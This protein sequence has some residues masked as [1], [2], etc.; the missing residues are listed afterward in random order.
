M[1]GIT[2]N[3]QI[4]Y[5]FFNPLGPV[6]DNARRTLLLGQS[7]DWELV[8]VAALGSLLYLA[9][10]LPHLQAA[11]GE[12]CRH[13][14]TGPSRSSTSGRSSGP[15][16]PVPKFYDQMKRFG[17][18]IGSRGRH[19]YRWVLK[20]VNLEVRPGGS[21]A[22]I[23][24]NGSGKTTLLK[25]ISQVTY[26]SAGRCDVRG[27]I[28]ALLS[29]TSGIQ[30]ELSGRENVFLYGA[31]LGHGP[32]DHPQAVR[33]DRRVRRSERRHRPAGQ[34]LLDGHADAARVLHRRLPRARRP[35]GRRGALG[36]ATPT[37]SR[38]AST[39]SG[40]WS[41]RA[42]PSSTSPTTWPR[43]RR[44]ASGPCGWPTP[45]SWPSGPTK[46]VVAKYRSAVEQNAALTTSTEGVVQV[47]KADIKAADGG[48]VRSECDL[49]VCLTLNSPEAHDANFFI[50]V[51]QGTAFPMFIVRYSGSFPAGDFEVRCRLRNVPLAHG[52]YSLWPAMSGHLTGRAS[53]CCRGGR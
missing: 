23:G 45:W 43:S 17:N 26:Q 30:P 51:S 10:R 16:G 40:R 2:I 53:R 14:L 8:G 18:S 3:L 52:R 50:G 41:A 15:T 35:P 32:P 19:E 4:V 49:D 22:L 27:R 24:I 36:R 13:C 5:G 28:G 47:L 44:R 38:S 31:V 20:D 34:V 39:G 46:D 9:V 7:P 1:G 11:G 48:Q 33:R 37:S 29:V 6:I 25:I 42:P 21:L 12:L